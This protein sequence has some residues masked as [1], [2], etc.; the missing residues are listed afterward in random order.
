M[1]L[2]DKVI[3]L[4]KQ[5]GWSQEQ[6]AEQLEVSRQAVSKWESGTSIPDLDRIVRMSELFGVSTD[7]L[8]KD[9]LEELELTGFSGTTELENTRRVSAEE[10]DDYMGLVQRTAGKI[11]LGV[12]LC[13]ISPICLILG[14]GLADHL[15]DSFGEPIVESAGVAMI[16][17]LVAIAVGLFIFNG[18]QL[19]RY[20]Y[21]EKE[22][23]VL[24]YGVQGIVEKKKADFEAAFRVS[25]MTGVVLCILGVIPIILAA[26]F[27]M[28]GLI[29]SCCVSAVLVF[30]A[31][32]VYLFVRFGMIW[33]SYQKLLQE[34]DYTSEKKRISGRMSVF[35]GVFWCSVTAVYLAIS[36]WNGAW[37]KTWIVWPVAGVVFGALYMILEAVLAGQSDK[38]ES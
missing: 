21:L 20:D 14:A 3:S 25:V 7:Y 10:A 22:S 17:V 24:Q 1:I 31:G 30:V 11:A 19:S 6:L 9:D 15:P 29:A 12:V 16:L 35:A 26:G 13:I 4:R 2:A 23:F 34:G 27:N 28:N 33:G 38:R 36:L 32:G 8:L 18:M 37:D 5:N